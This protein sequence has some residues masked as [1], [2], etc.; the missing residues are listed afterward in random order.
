MSL[1]S[2]SNHDDSQKNADPRKWGSCLWEFLH[3]MAK[4]YPDNPN[5]QYKASARQ[6]IFSLR[7]LL[8]CVTC[9]QNYATH[10]AK[11]QPNVES[12]L[13]LQEWVLWL[14]NEV[15]E[16]VKGAEP[17]TMEQIE[18]TYKL[19]ENSDLEEHW[20]PHNNNNTHNNNMTEVVS[21]NTNDS[22]LPPSL[23]QLLKPLTDIQVTLNQSGGDMQLMNVPPYQTQFLSPHM[24]KP[25]PPIRDIPSEMNNRRLSHM[26]STLSKIHA[27]RFKKNL[28]NF[29]VG[30]AANQR[31]N[32]VSGLQ[33]RKRLISR[34]KPVVHLDRSIQNRAT[35]P[36]QMKSNTP[37]APIP[38]SSMDRTILNR[39]AAPSLTAN[40][41][42]DN[43]PQ[44]RG[45][46]AKNGLQQQ[47]AGGCGCKGK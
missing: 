7:H 9:R 15:N 26:N 13:Q 12:S 10:L 46:G 43:T 27:N 35:P 29:N 24:Y 41:T 6:F 28:A 38:N 30:P 16:K 4:N 37:S 44:K 34:N 45:C 11:R 42:T 19:T 14:H 22:S 47:K 23:Q 33:Q 21:H 40:N 2:S 5:P 39:N 32:N 17:W 20:Q 8:P 1:S 18:A 3:T 25:P 36:M 31:P